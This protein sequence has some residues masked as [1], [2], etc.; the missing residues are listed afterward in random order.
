MLPPF[1][2]ADW[3]AQRLDEVVVCDVRW[4]LDGR[5]DHPAR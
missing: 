2:D 3:L 1:V 5:S 4:Y